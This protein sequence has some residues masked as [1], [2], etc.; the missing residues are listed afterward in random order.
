MTQHTT[1]K[2]LKYFLHSILCRWK[3]IMSYFIFP[4]IQPPPYPLK[5]VKIK[6]KKSNRLK[7]KLKVETGI[8][9]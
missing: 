8:K 5:C 7:L 6:F 3:Y 9:V 2:S 1:I 4:E